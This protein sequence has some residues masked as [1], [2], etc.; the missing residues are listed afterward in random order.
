MEPFPCCSS[1]TQVAREGKI[2]YLRIV[3]NNK[4]DMATEE[5]FFAGDPVAWGLYE[6]LKKELV[7][8]Y[9]EMEVRV[10]KTQVSFF[11]RLMFGCVSFARVR[12]KAEMPRHFITLTLGLPEPVD[13]PRIAVKCQPYPGRWAHHIVL[14]SN[15][16]I[17]AELLA[18]IDRAHQ[19]AQR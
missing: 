17:D 11:D 2:H 3:G 12:R 14:A 6:T 16:E 7:W 15:E 10:A 5:A 18:W 1:A 9:P 13:S 4:K 19:F 8:R